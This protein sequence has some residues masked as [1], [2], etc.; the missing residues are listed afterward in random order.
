MSVGETYLLMVSVF[1]REAFTLLSLL[2]LKTLHI[3]LGF[4]FER[5]FFVFSIDYLQTAILYVD[6]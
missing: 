5:L 6:L 2:I 4:Y 1:L 3:G